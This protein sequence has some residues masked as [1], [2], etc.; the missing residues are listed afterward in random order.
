ML[1]MPFCEVRLGYLESLLCKQFLMTYVITV[2]TGLDETVLAKLSS[3]WSK[4]DCLS[5]GLVGICFDHG[6]AGAKLKVFRDQGF[7]KVGD[8]LELQ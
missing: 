3:L 1:F 8:V 4:R 6:E 5:R 2:L 7:E